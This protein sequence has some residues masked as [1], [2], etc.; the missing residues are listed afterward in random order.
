MANLKMNEKEIID[1]Y[2]NS[3]NKVLLISVPI[4][5]NRYA[6]QHIE[7]LISKNYFALLNLQ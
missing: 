3:K 4:N 5:K 6:I 2:L 7:E 1:K